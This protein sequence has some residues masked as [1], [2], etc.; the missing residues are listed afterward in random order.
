MANP[1]SRLRTLRP[2]L[3]TFEQIDTE[4]NARGYVGTRLMPAFPVGVA[5]GT[6]SVITLKSLLANANA[7]TKR[8][9]TGGYNRGDYDFEDR[10]YLTKENGWE[11]PI[12]E[13][14]MNMYANF[15]DLE[16]V[17]TGRAWEHVLNSQ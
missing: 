7:D 3:S 1:V 8:T 14:E 17:A 11:E 6:F 12:D 16:T 2:E 9:S 15:F 10:S 13:R 5:G 4:M